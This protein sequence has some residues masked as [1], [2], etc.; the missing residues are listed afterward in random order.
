MQ[1]ELYR[2]R[3]KAQLVQLVLDSVQVWQLMEHISQ[4]DEEK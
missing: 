2:I 1:A 3:P 4:I